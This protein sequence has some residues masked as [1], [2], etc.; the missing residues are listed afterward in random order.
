MSVSSSRQGAPSRLL[1]ADDHPVLR[2][3]LR[4]LLERSGYEV[5]AE[6]GDGEEAMR[7]TLQERPDMAL[8]DRVMPGLSGLEVARRI[9]RADLGTRVVIISGQL[10][11]EQVVEAGRAGAVAF[12]SKTADAEQMRAILGAVRDG[13][14]YTASDACG[15]TIDRSAMPA[16]PP[17]GA[18]GTAGIELLTA[19][20]RE[21]LRLV[22]EGHSSLGVA[23]ILRLSPRTVETHRQ[24]IMGKLG[25]HSV[26][27]LTRFALQSGHL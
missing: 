17:V 14:S 5:V 13:S 7:L 12:I 8:L 26:A 19:R 18:A 24:H 2:G 4:K 10:G 21:V 27:G 22:A 15:M 23:A 16:R 20:E 25:I 9:V 11:A 3:A 6:A 1:I